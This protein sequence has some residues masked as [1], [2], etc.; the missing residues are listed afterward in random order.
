[1]E[2]QKR[3]QSPKISCLPTTATLPSAMNGDFGTSPPNGGRPS[4]ESRQLISHQRAW[5]RVR[6]AVIFQRRGSVASVHDVSGSSARLS[7]AARPYAATSRRDLPHRRLQRLGIPV[8]S[9]EPA[10][11]LRSHQLLEIAVRRCGSD[12]ARM[13]ETGQTETNSGRLNAFRNTLKADIAITRKV[14]SRG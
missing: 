1:M 11:G 5:Q 9:P 13:S 2:S 12:S 7:T 8:K 4:D 3:R 14:V 6:I 10:R